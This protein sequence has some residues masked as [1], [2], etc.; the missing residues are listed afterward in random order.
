MDDE[1]PHGLDRE[2]CSLCRQA[3][4]GA[5]PSGVK[6][7]PVAGRSPTP[8]A[9]RPPR[10]SSARPAAPVSLTP[11]EA[12]ARVRKVLFHSTAYGAW[13]SIA[14]SGL[15]TAE[16]VLGPG[17][18]RPRED[19]TTRDAPA[20]GVYTVREQRLMA[21]SRIEDHLD[22]IALPEWLELLN[23]RAYFFAQQKDLT[24]HLGRYQHTVGQDVLV[25]D[26]A[27]L[28]SAAR[29]RVEVTTVN[30][31]LPEGF[32]RCRCRGPET[33]VALAEF[34]GPPAD[35]VEVTVVDGL[36]SVAGLVGRVVRYH[37]GAAPEVLVG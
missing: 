6:R 2:W 22:G 25:F 12:L 13:E 21:R 26:T 29:G 31:S 37:P 5:P 33:F 24:T 16:Q 8:R 11:A 7:R 23:R 18:L 1:C 14:E 15:R 10:D 17:A 34:R 19:D 27:K 20:G 36:D 30:P 4:S 32:G 9:P 3:A 35:I 28:L